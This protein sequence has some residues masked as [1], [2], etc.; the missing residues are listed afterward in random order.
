MPNDMANRGVTSGAN[1]LSGLSAVPPAAATAFSRGSGRAPRRT[2]DVAH[3]VAPG[4]RLLPAPSASAC[5][6]RKLSP[7]RPADG[8]LCWWA[9]KP[10]RLEPCSA[11]S[12]ASASKASHSTHCI[13]DL[14]CC[15]SSS[16]N[17]SIGTLQKL[18]Y[19]FL[20]IP[21]LIDSSQFPR[22]V[23]HFGNLLVVQIL[24]IAQDDTRLPFSARVSAGP[25]A[26]LFG[27]PGCVPRCSGS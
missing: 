25:P 1:T 21:Y 2:Y 23:E 6:Q 16:T 18:C 24:Q 19:S 22:Q 17:L 14:G 9:S 10:V 13:P 4:P 5:R 15:L 7:P 20:F 8:Q 12:R 26:P 3:Q 11:P 27:F